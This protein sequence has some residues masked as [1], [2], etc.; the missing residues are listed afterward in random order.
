M[1]YNKQFLFFISIISRNEL[2]RFQQVLDNKL[3]QN[4]KTSHF[5]FQEIGNAFIHTQQPLDALY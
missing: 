5:V 1:I 3:M 2:A 4:L